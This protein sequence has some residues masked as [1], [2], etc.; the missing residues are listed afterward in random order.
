MRVTIKDVARKAGVSTATVSLVLHDNRRISVETRKR[1]LKAIHELEYQPS[2][3]ARGLVMKQTGNIGF[4]LTEDHFLRTEPFYTRIFLGTE[5]EARESSHFVLLT[6]IPTQFTEENS[7]PRFVTQQSVDGIIVAGKVPQLLV[8]KL[9]HYNMP[10]I[11]IDYYPPKGDYSAVLIDNILG[12]M[13][14]TEHLIKLGHKEIAFIGGDIEHP[15]INERYIGYKMALEK[16]GIRYRSELVITSEEATGK[17]SGLHAVCSLL[18][19]D[20]KFTAL[21]ACNDAMAIG[22]MECLRKRG[23]KIPDQVSVVGF[24]DIESDVFQDPP[25]TT[26]AVPKF[27]LGIEAMRLMREVLANKVRKN[28]KVLVPVELVLRK[29]TS[30]LKK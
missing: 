8:E 9:N 26:I 21:F 5:F 19:R 29:S 20:I 2:Q 24:D 1:V 28:K 4:I 23:L 10:F 7:L 25:L 30:P 17:E 22:A 15:S 27:D 14:A 16:H 13:V 11:F 6:T 3:L 12:G 18:D